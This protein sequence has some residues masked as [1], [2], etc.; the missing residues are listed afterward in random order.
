MARAMKITKE[1]VEIAIQYGA[2]FGQN[3]NDLRDNLQY[4]TEEGDVL[5]LI[6]GGQVDMNNVIFTDRTADSFFDYWEFDPQI[7]EMEN[8]FAP[9]QP[10]ETS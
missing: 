4:Y 1:N 5:Y 3:L 9:I 7:G 6:M 2:A 8:W 10:K